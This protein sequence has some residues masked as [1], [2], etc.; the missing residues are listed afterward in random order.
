MPDFDWIHICGKMDID[1]GLQ[2]HL[3]CTAVE[4]TRFGLESALLECLILVGSLV[5]W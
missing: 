3:K 4:R 1:K 5:Q 2:G